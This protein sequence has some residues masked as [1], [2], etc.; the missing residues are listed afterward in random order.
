MIDNRIYQSKNLRK[1]GLRANAAPPL[2]KMILRRV[3]AGQ[4]P[5]AS[6]PRAKPFSGQISRAA[7]QK[8]QR[9]HRQN[10]CY[11]GQRGRAISWPDLFVDL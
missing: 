4:P 7:A 2:R 6:S 9:T 1:G 10:R 11:R 8:G 5:G 3:T